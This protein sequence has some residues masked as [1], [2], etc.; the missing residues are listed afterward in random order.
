MICTVQ[1]LT[2]NFV[3]Q[4]CCFLLSFL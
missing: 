3:E 2:M 1:E 4:P